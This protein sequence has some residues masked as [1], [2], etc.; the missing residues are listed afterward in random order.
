MKTIEGWI[1]N[2]CLVGRG[3]KVQVI[4]ADGQIQTLQDEFSPSFY[5]GG[6]AKDLRALAR[7]VIDQPWDVR[8]A[9]TDFMDPSLQVPV[10]TLCFDVLNPHH[11]PIVVQRVMRMRPKLKY[12]NA[13]VPIVSQ[14]I[15]AR[16]IIPFV[17]THFVVDDEQR[18]LGIEIIDSR[19]QGSSSRAAG[20]FVKR[21]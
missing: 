17:V 21:K 8:L 2:I 18:I 5:A 7:F 19:K 11:F 10:Q 3:V 16:G 15:T 1:F 13:D 12:H 9:W 6:N 20:E 14:Y 4:D